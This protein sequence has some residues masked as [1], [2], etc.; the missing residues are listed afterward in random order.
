MTCLRGTHFRQKYI[1]E[2]LTFIDNTLAMGNDRGTKYH[3][4]LT[5][6][7][8][9]SPCLHSVMAL[10]GETV[11]SKMKIIVMIREPVARARSSWVAGK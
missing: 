10:Y 6:T 7:P 2:L 11:V 4:P 8:I 1:S 3:Q 9:P 5:P